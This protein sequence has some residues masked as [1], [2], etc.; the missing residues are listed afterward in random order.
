[1]IFKKS[2]TT[3]LIF[4]FGLGLQAQTTFPEWDKDGDKLIE[5]HEFT[6]K[7]RSEFFPAWADPF[8]EK[9]I[10]EEGFFKKSYAGLDTDNDNLLSDE[11]WL[12]GYNYFYDDYVIHEEIGM[13]DVNKDGKLEYNEYYDVIYNTEY[14]TDID[15]D[16]DNYISEYEL[17]EFAFNNWDID[18]NGVLSKFEF[19]A[20][21][22]Y[23]IDV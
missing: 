10:I 5:K 18:G 23:Y 15:S 1:M 22:F 14:F 4:L 21:K 19:N 20:F 2:L 17:A 6:Q 12:I 9:G 13:I 3:C 11:E 8:D 7:F 16:S